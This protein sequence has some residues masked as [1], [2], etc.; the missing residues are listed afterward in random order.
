MW[1]GLPPL[2]LLGAATAAAA[3]LD[4]APSAEGTVPAGPFR[5]RYRIEGE[6]RP[7][8]VVGSSVYYPRVFSA[9]LRRRLR[10]VFLDHRGFALSPGKVD[11]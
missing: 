1:H 6:G 11:R 10:L 3:G 4:R 8:I 9:G 5:L 7:A 2:L